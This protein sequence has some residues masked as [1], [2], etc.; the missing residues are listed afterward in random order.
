MMGRKCSKCGGNGMESYE[1]GE[2]DCGACLG[3]G[4][5]LSKGTLKALGVEV[6]A[7]GE[8]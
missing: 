2:G 5:V 7:K 4:R 8:G 3:T 1:S 6:P